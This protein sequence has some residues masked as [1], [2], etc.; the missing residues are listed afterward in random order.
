[1]KPLIQFLVEELVD[2]PD[3]VEVGEIVGDDATTYEIKVSQPDLGKVIG[4]QGRIANAIRSLVRA[5]GNKQGR[6]VFVE[7][8]A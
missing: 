4:K 2:F 6:R 7:I 1:L 3:A 5:I 8:G